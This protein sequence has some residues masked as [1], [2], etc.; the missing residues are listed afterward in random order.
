[1]PNSA[2]MHWVDRQSLFTSPCKQ[3]DTYGLRFSSV[4]LS[5]LGTV[6]VNS[7]IQTQLDFKQLKLRQ[8]I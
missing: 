1:M 2:G 8:Y 6:H 7:L 4:T 5:H 3:V